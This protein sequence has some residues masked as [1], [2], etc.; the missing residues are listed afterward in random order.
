M[1][2]SCGDKMG[3]TG[4]RIRCPFCGSGEDWVSY[5]GVLLY[6]PYWFKKLWWLKF[7]AYVKCKFCGA[8]G[9]KRNSYSGAVL[10]WNLRSR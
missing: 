2:F 3:M 8:R 6:M 9:P 5:D 1:K 4:I 7:G 10:A